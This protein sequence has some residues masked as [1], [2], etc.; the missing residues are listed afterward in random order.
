MKKPSSASD[1]MRPEY[2]PE[3]FTDLKPNR[4]AARPKLGRVH[5]GAASG[6]TARSRPQTKRCA[7]MR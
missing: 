6:K 2:G 1:D 4:F 3:F 7:K 5:A